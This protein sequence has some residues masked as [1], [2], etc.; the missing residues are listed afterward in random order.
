METNKE[1]LTQTKD[2]LHRWFHAQPTANELEGLKGF[3]KW[4]ALNDNGLSE[5]VVADSKELEHLVGDFMEKMQ[6]WPANHPSFAILTADELWEKWNRHLLS[7]LITRLHRRRSSWLCYSCQTAQPLEGV[8]ACEHQI[9]K[10]VCP[11]YDPESEAQEYGELI[12][13]ALPEQD[14]EFLPTQEWLKAT[15][16]WEFQ[17]IAS[18]L[19]KKV[20]EVLM[21]ALEGSTLAI[22]KR[23]EQLKPLAQ[24]LLIEH[25]RERLDAKIMG[26]FGLDASGAKVLRARSYPHQSAKERREADVRQR[27]AHTDLVREEQ[28]VRDTVR[29]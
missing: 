20:F 19:P 11:S 21:L 6:A 12:D 5:P 24:R 16:S 3:I 27:Q 18:L 26:S 4:K 25:E 1:L 7:F 2:Y 15:G 10:E 8:E 14:E 17:L 9:I 13:E 29:P 23:S 28:R 22:P